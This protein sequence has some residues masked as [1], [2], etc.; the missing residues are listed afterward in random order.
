[1]FI[2]RRTVYM[3]KLLPVIF[4]MAFAVMALDDLIVTNT[5]V[6]SGLIVASF[7]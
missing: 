1:M 7:V 2:K 6:D 4:T 3:R 5:F